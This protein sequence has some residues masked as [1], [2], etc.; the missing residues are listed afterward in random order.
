MV[1]VGQY[2]RLTPA[3]DAA[4]RVCGFLTVLQLRVLLPLLLLAGFLFT[5]SFSS[6]APVTLDA[7]DRGNFRSD[8]RNNAPIEN[9]YTGHASTPRRYNSFFVFDLASLAGTVD[10]ATLLMELEQYFGPYSTLTFDV[11]DVSATATELDTSFAASD[12]NGIAIYNDLGSGNIYAT[13]TVSA[14]DVGTTLNIP[15]SLLAQSNIESQLGGTFAIGVA[16]QGP[17]SGD[18][19][20]RFGESGNLV[21]IQLE[22]ELTPP[23]IPSISNPVPE[24]ASW[25]CLASM[26]GMIWRA[27]RSRTRQLR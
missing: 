24:P 15:L 10:N 21:P 19:Y 26:C 11:F 23:I 5:P 16:V 20:V 27:S 4:H 6:A 2:L 17:D 18:Y 14:A 1:L 9:T 7:V 25:I 22:L 8:G 3:L 12:T 13:E